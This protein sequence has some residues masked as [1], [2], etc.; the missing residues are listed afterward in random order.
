MFSAL[1]HRQTR[2]PPSFLL[3]PLFFL[4][5]LLQTS[6]LIHIPPYTFTMFA[7]R[8]T[9]NLF[10]KRAFSASA[11]Q[12]CCPV[13]IA[14]AP[15]FP[16]THPRAIQLADIAFLLHLGLQGRRPRCRRW[17]W[18]APLPPF[19]AQP[20]CFRARPLRHQG[21]PWYVHHLRSE[22]ANNTLTTNPRCRC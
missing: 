14:P 2:L 22:K 17:H 5:S 19:E 8:Q 18:P 6:I 16:S 15:P 12:V 11:S 9:L 13:H 4:S 3:L 21:W 7:A 20:P 1:S 10:Q